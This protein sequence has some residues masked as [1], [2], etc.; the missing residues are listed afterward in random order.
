LN[1]NE[2]SEIFENYSSSDYD[3]EPDPPDSESMIDD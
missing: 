2:D 1:D 3:D